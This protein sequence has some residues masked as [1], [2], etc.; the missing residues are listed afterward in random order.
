M[1]NYPRDPL[2]DCVRLPVRSRPP[3]EAAQLRKRHPDL[4]PNEK[5]WVLEV[6]TPM[7][8]VCTAHGSPE[9]ERRRYPMRFMQ[10]SRGRIQSTA[11]TE[12][13]SFART[14]AKTRPWNPFPKSAETNTYLFGEWPLCTRC[15]QR[16]RRLQWASRILMLS[17]PVLIAAYTIARTLLD[18]LLVPLFL[19][20]APGWCPIGIALAGLSFISARTYVRCEPLVDDSTVLI[21]AHPNFTAAARGTSNSQ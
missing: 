10:A 18:G 16:F 3:A 7:P 8:S 1:A 20:I 4:D 13:T 6:A 14:L 15:V 2:A 21:H 17:G 12:L 11:A 9:V 5:F 19:F